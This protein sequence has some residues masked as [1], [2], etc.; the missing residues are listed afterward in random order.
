MDTIGLHFRTPAN[1]FQAGFNDMNR[2]ARDVYP[3]VDKG[4][5]IEVDGGSIGADSI[6][7]D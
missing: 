3:M 5:Y 4:N 7:G 2:W 1:L 6:A